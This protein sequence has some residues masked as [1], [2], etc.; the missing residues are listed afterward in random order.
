MTLPA[1]YGERSQENPFAVTRI[2]P[3]FHNWGS[4]PSPVRVYFE[5]EPY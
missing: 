1:G 2:W 3:R 4:E 5:C